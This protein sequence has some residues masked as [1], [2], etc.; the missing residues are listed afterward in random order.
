MTV[1]RVSEPRPAVKSPFAGADVC[2]H[3]GLVLR[4]GARGP[5]FD[6]EV[7]DFNG[8]AGLAVQTRRG[9]L[10]WKFTTIANPGW[11]LV[12]REYMFALLAPAHEAVRVLP[13]AYRTPHHLLTCRLR[14]DALVDWFTWL[15]DHG[16]TELAQVS[17]RHCAEYLE[18]R[19]WR[20]DRHGH[21]IG[22]IGAARRAQA[23]VPVIELADYRDLFTA[24]RYCSGFRPWAGHHVAAPSGRGTA[25][26]KTS[27]VPAEVFQPMLAAALYLV[28][29]IGPRI[30]ALDQARRAATLV[31][32]A[33]PTGRP[34]PDRLLAVVDCHVAE[35]RPFDVVGPG[36]VTRRV[37]RGWDPDDPL[38]TVNLNRIAQ[39]AGYRQLRRDT[40][41]RLRAALVEALARVGVGPRWARDAE[42]V[43]RADGIGQVPWTLPLRGPETSVLTTIA[44]T[45]CLITTAAVSGMRAGELMEL[46][47]GCQRHTGGTGAEPIRHRLRSKLI[48]G[49]PSGG[50]NDE[51]VVTEEVFR[52][53]ELADQLCI[54]DD[55]NAL[56]FGRFNFP[57]LYQRFRAWVNGPAG[58]RLGLT[59]IGGE[60]VTP[61]ML[62]RTLAIELAYRPG[63]LFAAKIHLRHVSVATA[64]GYAARPG[65]AQARLLAEVS[66]HEQQRNLTLLTQ[67][68]HD[69]Q[70]GRRPA[71]PG[72]RELI[73]FFDTVDGRRPSD[74]RPPRLA[75]DPAVRNLIAQRA[76]TLHLQPANYCWFVDPA[77]A[78]CLKLAGTPA[79]DKPMAGMCDST[80]CPQATHHPCHRPVW[81]EQARTLTTLIGGLSRRQSTERRRL[82]AELARVQ[83]VI[84]GIDAAGGSPS[85]TP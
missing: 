36:A 11:R 18:H 80:R 40:V 14:L 38:L 19:S 30:A 21:P 23:T 83:Q 17:D 26:N 9:I 3:A 13:R 72:A 60:P 62:R 7:W 8:V 82:Q 33:L 54:D 28:E 43:A 39:E 76:A 52:A 63:G 32:A 49:Q 81:D 41:P 16:I 46:R 48:K 53:I 79:A 6:D 64:E 35:G 2:A 50:I 61:R 44:R 4:D 20:R 12:A 57:Q 29:E 66:K 59:P 1:P 71:G 34:D 65:G 69:Y 73:E 42:L 15:T 78:L 70:Q 27:P 77:Q 84:A 67:A 75:S 22:P 10:R 56:L 74:A 24:D 58:T 55:P 45:A 5:V 47:R 37:R 51:W 25:E 85:D 68:Y 31:E